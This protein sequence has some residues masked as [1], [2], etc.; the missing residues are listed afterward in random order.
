MP[1]LEETGSVNV[2]DLLSKSA[3]NFQLLLIP[4]KDAAGKANVIQQ[5]LVF[6]PTLHVRLRAM[7]SFQFTKKLFGIDGA[8]LY[9]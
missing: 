7:V 5:I 4:V 2:C 6:V 9:M 1:A 3:S 8:T